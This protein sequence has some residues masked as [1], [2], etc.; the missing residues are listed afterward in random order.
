MSMMTG[1]VLPLQLSPTLHCEGRASYM[2]WICHW[3]L[4]TVD[5]L[6]CTG[7]PGC[8]TGMAYGSLAFPIGILKMSQI[9]SKYIMQ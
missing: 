7:C 2:T 6:W 5:V 1:L 3:N 4:C 8:A 9:P